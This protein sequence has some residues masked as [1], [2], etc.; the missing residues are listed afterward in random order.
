MIGYIN[1]IN[2]L[3]VIAHLYLVFFFLGSPTWTKVV[4]VKV[5]V[6]EVGSERSAGSSSGGTSGVGV[7]TVEGNIYSD[8]K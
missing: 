1:K 6:P 2:E 7:K 4:L 3:E 8:N 5:M